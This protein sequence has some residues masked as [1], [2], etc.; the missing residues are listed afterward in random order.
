MSCRACA[1]SRDRV[2]FKSGSALQTWNAV[3]PG[4]FFTLYFMTDVVKCGGGVVTLP[5]VDG[6]VFWC[7]SPRAHSSSPPP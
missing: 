5:D 2:C 3:A 6:N 4:G 1:V 7:G